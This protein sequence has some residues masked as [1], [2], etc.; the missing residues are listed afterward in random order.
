[1]QFVILVIQLTFAMQMY[2]KDL[3]SNDKLVDSLVDRPSSDTPSSKTSDSMDDVTDKLVDNLMNK[4]LNRAPYAPSMRHAVFGKHNLLR[5]RGSPLRAA[6]KDEPSYVS[7]AFDGPATKGD[8]VGEAFS[9]PVKKLQQVATRLNL[10]G[11][12]TPKLTDVELGLLA[13]GVS[14]SFAS[15]FFFQAKIIEVLVPSLGALVAWVGFNA[16]YNGKVAVARGKEIAATTLQAAAEAELCLAQAE[17]AKAV[18]PL[19]VGISMFAAAFALVCPAIIAELAALGLAKTLLSELYLVCPLFSGIAA[20]VAELAAQETLSLAKNAAGVGARRFASSG[21]V[22]R[23]WLSATEQIGRTTSSLKSKWREF[24]VRM[25]PLA[26]LAL[27]T[28]GDLSFKAIVASFIGASQAG[29]ALARAEYNL[30]GAIESVALKTRAAALADTYANQGYRAGS[31]LPFTS[32]LGG[33]CAAT[34]VA[35]MELLPMIPSNLGDA[36]VCVIFPALGAM[37]AAA[38]SIS[39]SCAE[40]DAEAATSAAT[41]LAE[42]QPD[43]AERNPIASA[44]NRMGRRVNQQWTSLSRFFRLLAAG[45]TG[46]SARKCGPAVA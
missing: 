8:K 35:A 28:P 20:A 33:L 31:I 34:T 30:A 11:S 27:V 13:A 7:T 3:P 23:T 17:R 15:P 5:T 46:Q 45:L 43:I 39:K 2:A 44:Y 24:A 10:Q 32:A 14:G 29:W 12:V 40:I 41:T 4:V 25:M 21:D 9:E 26:V 18:I 16:E 42:S 6:A 37:F 36:A 22:G 1:M 38:A 19:C